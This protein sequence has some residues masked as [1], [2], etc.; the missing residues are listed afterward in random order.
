LRLVLTSLCLTLA[1]LAISTRTDAAPIFF[2]ADLTGAQEVPPVTTDAFG[3]AD[4]ELNDAQT[5]LTFTATIFGIDVN[6]MQTPDPMDNLA[7]AHIHAPAPIGSNAGVVWGFFGM[8]FNDTMFPTLVITPFPMGVGGVFTSG[9]NLGEG[10]AGTNL[11][12]QLPNILAGLSYI[13]FH[14]V[15]FPGGEVR[16]QIRQVAEP[17]TLALVGLTGVAVTLRRRMQRSRRSGHD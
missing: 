11:A 3:F 2:H 5:L 8:P 12:L 16:G 10:N 7:A 15:R 1:L 6:G 4:F 14:T 13:N 17:A 9:W